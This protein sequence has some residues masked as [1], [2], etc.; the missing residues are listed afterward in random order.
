M[1]Q[2][3][4]PLSATKVILSTPAIRRRVLQLAKQ[5]AQHYQSRSL[6]LVCVLKGS[7]IFCADFIRALWQVGLIDVQLDCLGI[8]SYQL[9]TQSSKTPQLTKDLDLNPRGRHV[10]IVED[11]VDTGH[12]LKAIIGLIKARE[13]ASLKTLTLLNKPS[14]RQI[15]VTVD[16]VGFEVEGWV[17]GYGLD[18]AE[19]YRGRPEICQRQAT[20]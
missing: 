19:Y 5:I 18:T 10:L 3:Q 20:S 16:Y 2:S 6:I 9:T 12:S 11:I 14:R 7:F 1:Y 8:S 13:P 15:A 17:E 4:Y